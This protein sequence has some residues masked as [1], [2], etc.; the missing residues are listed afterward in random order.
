MSM[1]SSSSNPAL[2][3]LLPSSKMWY[4]RKSWNPLSLWLYMFSQSMPVYTDDIHHSFLISRNHQFTSADETCLKLLQHY[5][6]TLFFFF[7][8]SN[9]AIHLTNFILSWTTIADESVRRYI[10]HSHTLFN[11]L[12][13]F[14]FNVIY[15]LILKLGGSSAP[16]SYLLIV[17]TT[18]SGFPSEA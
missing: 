8:K 3:L 7:F 12:L 14:L 17:L 11:I 2:A 4:F 16:C 15:Y 6:Q 13:L 9:C 18:P 5:C 10:L 1:G